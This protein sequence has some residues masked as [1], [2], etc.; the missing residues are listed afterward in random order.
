MAELKME[1]YSYEMEDEMN[2]QTS[3]E[4]SNYSPER[5]EVIVVPL[6][7]ARHLQRISRMEKMIAFVLLVALVGVGVLMINLRTSIT[8]IEH[9]ISV[10]Q[11][12]ISVDNA[13]VL[14]LEQEKS[15][16]SKSERIR[17]IAEEQGL[18]I[19]SENL[20]KVKK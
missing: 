5:P 9:D 19:Q 15:E 4:T 14:R 7:P 1:D 16:L 8:R 3:Y 10:I 18:T 13:E 20:R 17:K 2:V 12:E 11:G 6:S